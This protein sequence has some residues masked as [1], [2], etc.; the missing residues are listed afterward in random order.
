MDLPARF[1]K[2]EAV[3]SAVDILLMNHEE[4]KN[5]RSNGEIFISSQA[6]QY[7]NTFK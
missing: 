7:L 6:R 3:A 1:L 2:P 4:R 5:Q